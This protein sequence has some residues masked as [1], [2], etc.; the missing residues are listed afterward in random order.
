V[1]ILDAVV[2][3][4]LPE[5]DVTLGEWD[6]TIPA[7]PAARWLVAVLSPQGGA[8]VPGLL[9]VQDRRDIWADF[10]RGAFDEQEL[11]EVERDALQAAAG[12][13]W[14]EAD[15]LIRTAFTSQSWP[16]VSGEMTH[17][18]I[19]LHAISLSSWLNWVYVLVINRCKD[20]A[21]RSKFEAQ[22]QAIPAG[23]TP[24]DLPE[25]DED[26]AS[27]FMAAMGEQEA[28]FGA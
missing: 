2:A 1:G 27:A 26:M 20:D 13:P 12:R 15:R 25:T 8:I 4:D 17:R 10:A 5:I 6:Y 11:A 18:G 9:E 21:E 24:D 23:V 28:L 7:L 3:I 14:W 22:L 19:N 16:I